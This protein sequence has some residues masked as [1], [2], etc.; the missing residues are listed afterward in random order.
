MTNRKKQKQEQ[1]IKITFTVILEEK[2]PSDDFS[3]KNLPGES[4]LDVA[5]RNILAVFWRE[6]RITPTIDIVFAKQEPVT[7]ATVQQLADEFA[8]QDEIS[9]AAKLRPSL[10]EL[11]RKPAEEQYKRPHPEKSIGWWLVKSFEEYLEIKIAVHEQSYYLHESGQP[12]TKQLADSTAAS[13]LFLLGGRKDLSEEHE[14]L[15]LAKKVIPVTLGPKV[16][17]ASTCISAV[18]Y[19]LLQ[20][21]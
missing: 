15:V 20:R 14:R 9:M 8:Q 11:A 4:K 5:C 13:Y 10:Q 1:Q 6:P 18:Q 16:Y 2:Q 21:Q 3:L 7:I 17:L 12:I 19:E